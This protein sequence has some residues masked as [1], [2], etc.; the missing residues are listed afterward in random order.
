[1]VDLYVVN[2]CLLSKWLGKL[3]TIEGLWLRK[4]MIRII[5]CPTVGLDPGNRI[6]GKALWESKVFYLAFVSKKS[7]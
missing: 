5:Y 2:K 6:S 7:R 1:V 4:N 3:E